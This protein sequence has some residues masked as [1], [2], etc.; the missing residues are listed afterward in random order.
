MNGKLRPFAL[1]KRRALH[2]YIVTSSRPP[3]LAGLV[4]AATIPLL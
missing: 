2:N 1:C 3:V 4:Y